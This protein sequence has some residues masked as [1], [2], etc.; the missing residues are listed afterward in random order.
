MLESDAQVVFDCRKVSVSYGS[1]NAVDELSLK[2]AQGER[3]AV[4]GSNGAGKTSLL[5]VASGMRNASGGSIRIFGE[6]P[7][8]AA[9]KSKMT[10]LPQVLTYPSHLKVKEIFSLIES[11]YTK[12]NLDE[13][14][15]VLDLKALLERKASQL[16]GGENRKL[17]VV[18]SLLSEPDL[19]IL[20][21]PTAN[22]DIEGCRSIE[23]LIEDYFQDKHK[24]LI[25]SSHLMNEVERLATRI[26]VMKN[27]RIVAEGPKDQIKRE[28]GL[29]KLS[30]LSDQ[31]ELQLKS[32]KSR[33]HRGDHYQFLG[34]DSDLMIKEA[35]AMDA[36]ISKIEVS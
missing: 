27:G 4:L 1:V 13:L 10:Y 25:F 9:C 22:I 18:S 19:V 33:E 20:D 3:V 30:F 35:L 2:I 7:G 24:T 29:R 6:R 21:E 14:I 5:S 15:S 28:F 11:H 12:S 26:V 31:G 17:G 23:G 16:S 34:E 36:N 8:S 32:A